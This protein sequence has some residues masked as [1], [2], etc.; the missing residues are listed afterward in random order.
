MARSTAD[1]ARSF[2]DGLFADR[3]TAHV[4]NLVIVDGD[5]FAIHRHFF[6]HAGDRGRVA[7]DI[8]RVA[9]GRIA[10]RWEVVQ[11]VPETVLHGNT[12][13]C[14]QGNNFA[15]AR[16]ASAPAAP[17]GGWPNRTA[18][19]AASVAIVDAYRAELDHDVRGAVNRWLAPDYRQHSPHIPDGAEAAIA[20]FLPRAGKPKVTY[21]RVIAEGDLVLY[22]RCVVRP[23]GPPSGRMQVDIFRVTNGK[24]SEHWDVM[25]GI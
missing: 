19:A 23:G 11:A 18:S 21:S 10:E 6:T 9:D 5:F 2:V 24:I 17:R 20:Y 14:G 15:E 4:I 16:A 13:W 3:D 1:V 8:A 22:H 25:H 7:A 12:M